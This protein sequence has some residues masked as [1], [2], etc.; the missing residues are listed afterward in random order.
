MKK[1]NNESANNNEKLAVKVFRKLGSLV[2]RMQSAWAEWM[3]RKT[4]G[5]SKKTLYISLFLFVTFSIVYNSMVLVGG[6]SGLLGFSSI[7][8]PSTMTQPKAIDKAY[9][10]EIKRVE[11]FT[12]YM[13]SLKRSPMGKKTYDSIMKARPGLLDSARTIEKVINKF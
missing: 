1:Q 7:K 11:R 3:N 6:N 4:A 9:Q 10:R 2:E 13:D 5:L 12:Q 8:L